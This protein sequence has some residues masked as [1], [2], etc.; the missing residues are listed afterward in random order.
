[1]DHGKNVFLA[2]AFLITFTVWGQ[3]MKYDDLLPL[4]NNK[5]YQ[6]AAPFLKKYVKENRPN[7]NAYLYLGIIYQENAAAEFNADRKKLFLDSANLYFM[8][9]GSHLTLAHVKANEKYYQMYARR[10]LRSGALGVKYEDIRFDLEMR[11]SSVTSE[12]LN[13]C[14]AVDET[15]EKGSV[16]QHTPATGSLS[17]TGKY[18]A[19]VIGVSVYDNN[20]LNLVRPAQDASLFARLLHKQYEFDSVDVNLLLNPTRQQILNELYAYRTKL[21]SRDNLL[22][23]YAGHGMYDEDAGQGYWWPRNADSENPANWLSNSDLRDQIRGIKTAHTLLIADA[24]F[25]GGI[26]RTRASPIKN[27]SFDIVALYKLPSRRAITSG[28]MTT[29]PDQSVF[30]DYLLRSL[31][32]NT[33]TYLSSQVLF[34]SFRTKVINN[35]L[36]IPQDGIISETGDEGGDF[37]FIRNR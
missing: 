2:G 15:D 3:S 4:L 7:A 34:E 25:S 26:F 19:L 22:I 21:T 28:T 18:F 8:L 35:T 17:H 27:A 16:S 30:F 24:C 36:Q 9:A 5:Q 29:V 20:K 37:I 23:F 11:K 12:L 6:L 10:D 14:R 33:S 32:D 1:M 13:L 31:R